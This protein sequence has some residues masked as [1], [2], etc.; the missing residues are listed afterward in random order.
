M[1][2]IRRLMD[3]KI[4][5]HGETMGRFQKRLPK[6][7]ERLVHRVERK[8]FDDVIPRF[9]TVRGAPI[10]TRIFTFTGVEGKTGD[11]IELTGGGRRFLIAYTKLVDYIA[12][13]GWVWFT[14]GFTSA[15]RLHD[16]I[17]GIDIKRSAVSKW[18]GALAA[19]QSGRCYYD[20][21]HDMASSE[22][23]HLL[24]WSF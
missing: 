10:A 2:M 15:P 14:E 13:S 19:M 20:D 9:H 24:P 7:Y 11:T 18:R 8:C 22:V 4:V 21:S 23:D 12:V 17:S 16:K 3:E 1:V 5:S 6:E